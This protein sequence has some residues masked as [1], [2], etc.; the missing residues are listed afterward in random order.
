MSSSSEKVSNEGAETTAVVETLD[1]KGKHGREVATT[2]PVMSR[3]Q[4]ISAYFTV[5]AAAFGL[6][7]C[8]DTAG[9]LLMTSLTLSLAQ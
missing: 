5:A 3:K 4:T 7:R 9:G 2:V 1:S 6:I 8:V